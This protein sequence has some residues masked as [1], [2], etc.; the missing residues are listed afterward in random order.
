MNDYDYDL[1]YF[2]SSNTPNRRSSDSNRYRRQAPKRRTG[3]GSAGN[4]NTNNRNQRNTRDTGSTRNTNGNRKKSTPANSRQRRTNKKKN[5]KRSLV[6]ALI[7]ILV[8]VIA[9][10]VGIVKF[11]IDNSNRPFTF[12]RD[13]TVS[14]IDISGLTYEQAL[15]K[16]KEN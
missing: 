7:V 8:L 6:F 15:D 12:S 14:D 5:R 10:T 1:S 2:S 16:L 3:S 9:V 11:N 13:V 4:R